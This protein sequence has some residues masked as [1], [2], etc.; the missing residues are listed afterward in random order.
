MKLAIIY[1]TKTGNTKQA[2]EWIAEGMRHVSNVEAKT[3]P[4]DDLNAEYVDGAK[5]CRDRLLVLDGVDDAGYACMAVAS[6]Q[7]GACR[8]VGRSVCHGAVHPRRRGDGDPVHSNQRACFRN[9]LLLRRSGV[10]QACYPHGPSG[11]Q[12]Q[13][14][15]A[16]RHGALPGHLRSLRRALC[17][18]GRRAVAWLSMT[19]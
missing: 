8:E 7:A 5:G 3:F 12:W 19:F 16:Q 9:A 17:T 10:G 6:E 11:C 2:A 15:I 14:G 13:R 1:H 4:I 18:K